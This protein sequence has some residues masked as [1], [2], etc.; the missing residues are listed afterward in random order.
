MARMGKKLRE[1]AENSWF[2]SFLSILFCSV[3][4][5]Y[6]LVLENNVNGNLRIFWGYKQSQ[7]DN[8]IEGL[9][10]REA[11]EADDDGASKVPYEV[12]PFSNTEDAR[13]LAT[14]I[15]SRVKE[16]RL[17]QGEYSDSKYKLH[18]IVNLHVIPVCT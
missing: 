17:D 15:S 18:T 3:S 14:D 6:D 16:I 12:S 4:L 1:S 10:P 7:I 5:F 13:E 11:T 2:L 8:Q 9:S